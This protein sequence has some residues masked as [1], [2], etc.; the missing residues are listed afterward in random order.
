MHEWNRAEW[1][2]DWEHKPGPFAVYVHTPLCGTCK[3]VRRMLEVAAEILPD[4]P[5]AEANINLMPDMAQE[6]QIA[7]VPCLILKRKDG[8]WTKIYRF[9]SVMELVERLRREREML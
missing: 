7:S 3:A 8:T 9:P 4:L 1:R 6:L 5:L 2:R